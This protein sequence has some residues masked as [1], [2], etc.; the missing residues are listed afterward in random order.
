MSGKRRKGWG[1]S[2]SRR[3]FKRTLS[4]QQEQRADPTIKSYKM[5]TGHWSER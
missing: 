3:K 5:G 4:Q 2:K 1:K